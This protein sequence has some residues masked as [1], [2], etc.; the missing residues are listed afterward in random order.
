MVEVIASF[1]VFAIGSLSVAAL[2]ANSL[3]VSRKNQ[4]RVQAAQVAAQAVQTAR[5]AVKNSVAIPNNSTKSVLVGTTTF[6][7]ATVASWTNVGSIG[8]SCTGAVPGEVAYRRIQA[9]VTWPKMTGTPAVTSTTIATPLNPNT[10]T[11]PVQLVA[12]D[13]TPQVGQTITLTA[14][15]GSTQTATTDS[16]GC[17]IFAQLTPQKYT[18][19]VNTTGYVD[20]TSA[21]A[22]NHTEQV[23]QSIPGITPVNVI[24]YDHPANLTVVPSFA[25]GSF[26]SALYPLPSSGMEVTL[27][28]TGWSDGSSHVYSTSGGALS[29]FLTNRVFPFAAAPGSGYSAY[30]GGCGADAAIGGNTASTPLGTPA[31]NGTATL[32]VPVISKVITIKRSGTAQGGVT[33]TASDSPDGCSDTYTLSGTTSNVA[34]TKGQIAFSLP[35]GN[36]IFSAVISGATRSSTS[37]AVTVSSSSATTVNV[38]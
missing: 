12:G 11:I 24:F 14:P 18:V 1:V 6:T 9:S 26:T 22:T 38:S 20:S 16:N 30:A 2:L 21:A 17:V 25:S 4:Q 15:N 19:T 23:G 5:D 35:Y 37:T 29:S 33:V 27:G 32:A 13:K 34:A 3:T 8:S 10:M 28:Q 7:V 31:A 36:Y